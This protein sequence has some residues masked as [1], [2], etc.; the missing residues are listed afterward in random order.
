MSNQKRD[1]DSTVARIAGN[2]LSSTF[3]GRDFRDVGLSTDVMPDYADAVKGAVR[4]ARAIIGETK[5][6]ERAPSDTTEG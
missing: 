6:T 5:R 3:E 2:L 1:Y 4:L